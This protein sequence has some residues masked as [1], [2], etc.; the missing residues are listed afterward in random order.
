MSI[1]DLWEALLALFA[2]R[3]LLRLLKEFSD[4]VRSFAVMLATSDK[5]VND[6]D[7]PEKKKDNP[8]LWKS[9]RKP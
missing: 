6:L 2:M 5:L 8:L 4:F 9:I 3:I 7:F 1:R